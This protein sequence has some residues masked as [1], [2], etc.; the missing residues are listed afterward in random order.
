MVEGVHIRVCPGDI[1][2]AVDLADP[3][4]PYQRPEQKGNNRRI[5]STVPIFLKKKPLV[6]KGLL[7]FIGLC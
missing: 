1:I 2:Q 4:P 6:F 7:H 3:E 5:K